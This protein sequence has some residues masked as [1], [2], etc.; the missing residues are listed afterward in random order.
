MKRYEI[1]LPHVVN[2]AQWNLFL[3]PPPGVVSRSCVSG[4]IEINGKTRT[5][6]LGDWVLDDN[7]EKTVIPGSVFS[8][9]YKEVK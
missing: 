9:V 8:T 2:A 4:T 7:G 5:I 6:M 1:K 3:N